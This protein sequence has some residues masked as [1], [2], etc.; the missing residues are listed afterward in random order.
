MNGD[1]ADL[2]DEDH[3]VRTVKGRWVDGSDVDGEAFRLRDDEEGLSVNWIERF[4][5]LEKAAQL[6]EIRRL[7]RRGVSG[8]YRLAEVNVGTVKE[9][10]AAEIADL[11]IR[12][13][14]LE[15]EGDHEEDPSHSEIFG[16]PDPAD[17]D[18]AA[19]IGEMIAECVRE[20][21]PAKEPQ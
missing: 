13:T 3:V 4:A 12:N 8:T 7:A 21:H 1:G 6:S 5:G 16:L 18:R 14:P 20:L 11:A 9:H 17:E 2:P 19:V 10:L 15:A